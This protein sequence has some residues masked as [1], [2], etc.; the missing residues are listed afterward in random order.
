MMGTRGA[1]TLSQ[2]AKVQ[3]H[4]KRTIFIEFVF[5]DQMNNVRNE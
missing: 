2:R 4:I 3:C 5:D 1:E